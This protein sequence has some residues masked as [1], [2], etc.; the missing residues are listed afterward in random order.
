M[1]ACPVCQSDLI[2]VRLHPDSQERMILCS[3][4]SCHYPMFE[5]KPISHFLIP[6][7]APRASQVTESVGTSFQREVPLSRHQSSIPTREA[8]AQEEQSVVSAQVTT[9]VTEKATVET[10][11]HPPG[12]QNQGTFSFIEDDT[13]L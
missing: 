5:E 10:Q 2:Q 7:A 4:T 3:N 12:N 13:F 1:Q 8:A 6:Q 9:T 11:S